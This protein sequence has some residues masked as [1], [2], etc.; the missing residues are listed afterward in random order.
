MILAASNNQAYNSLIIKAVKYAKKNANDKTRDEI[1]ALALDK[2]FVLFGKE[3]LNIV[4]GRVSTE[5]DARF[6]LNFYFT[7]LDFH[8]IL[9]DLLIKLCL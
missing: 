3:I 8:L 2:L 7:F 6:I 9:K 5:V 4:P 1:R